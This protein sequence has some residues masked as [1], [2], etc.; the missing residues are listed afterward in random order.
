MKNQS[1]YKKM[2]FK[3]IAV[4]VSMVAAQSNGYASNA[5]ATSQM[6]QNFNEMSEPRQRRFL[7]SST[8]DFI[9]VSRV[10]FRTKQYRSV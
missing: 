9:I 5:P 10:R 1:K 7:V 6:A 3:F 2:N 8:Q 4:A